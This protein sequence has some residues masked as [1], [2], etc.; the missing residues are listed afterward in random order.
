MS[1]N[2]NSADR[3]V[4]DLK[5]K[6]ATLEHALAA[7]D[8][9]FTVHDRQGRFLY[10]NPRG[11]AAQNLRLEDV[12]G[13]N[14]RELGF[15]EEVGIPFDKQVEQVFTEEVT[16]RTETEFPTKDG[17]RI[18]ENVL[19]PA[20]D[21]T[22]A[23]VALVATRQDITEIKT[24]EKAARESEEQL[25][26]I[27][28]NIP[29][30]VAYVGLDD[31]CYRSVNNKFEQ[32][33][34]RPREEIIGQH[35]KD[36]IGES[37]Y[38]FA[39]KYID[40]VRSGQAVS[41]ENIFEVEDGKRWIEVNYAPTF[42]A[43]GKPEGI[44]VL[45]FDITERKRADEALRESQEQFA[46]F[47]DRLP[48]GVFIKEEDSTVAYVN[49]YIKDVL[50]GEHWVGR[51]AHAAFPEHPDLAEA[52]MADDRNAL[53][54][55]Q[56]EIEEAM[57]DKDGNERVFITTKFRISRAN[58]SPLLGGIGL[59]I[60]DRVKAERELAAALD[61]ARHLRDQAEKANRAKDIF[62]ANMS[63][64]LRTP[65]NAI[66]GYS[67]LMARDVNVTHTQQEYLETIARSGEYLL[68]LIN[69]VLTMSKIEAGRTTLQENA[70]DLHQQIYGL[71]EM[72]QLRADHKGLKLLLDIAPDVPNYIYADESKLRQVLINLLSN[73]VKFTFEGGVTLRIKS[74]LQEVEDT[75]AMLFI[76]VEDTGAGI[77]Q[78]EID[79]LFEPFTQTTSGQQSQEGTG[80]GLSISQQFVNL[81]GGKLS[82]RSIVEQGTVFHVQIPVTLADEETV[83]KLELS[84]QRR[85][86]GVEPAQTAPDGGPF[87]LLV[88][89]DNVPNRELLVKLLTPFGFELRTADNGKESVE[90]WE[91]W[92]PHLVWMDMR[93]PVMDGYEATRQIKARA[94]TADRPVIVVA[95][96]AS[97]FD[98]DRETIFI[99][100]C[101][102]LIRKPFRE[103]EIFDA[104]HRH[105][106]LRFIYETSTPAPQETERMPSQDMR[107]AIERLPVEWVA[108]LR[109][110]AIAL[111]VERTL[112]LVEVIRPRES[113]LADTLAAWVGDFEF[114]KLLALI[115]SQ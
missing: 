22:G 70:F 9:H 100:G 16:I 44:V 78:E 46:L 27:T 33:Y 14:W 28:D 103:H 75:G 82:V 61:T 62:L 109:Q 107:A 43:Q 6:I 8:V 38:Q 21:D 35:I 92:Q 20:R 12:E 58:K 15:P 81:M 50:G 97:A 32:A 5:K 29:A 34:A 111:D 86:T 69:N 87:R 51:D 39:L 74:Q 84:P 37:N 59:D 113:H 94:K 64:E 7:T 25:R 114:D 2:D 91:Q 54:Q 80:L 101:D 73:A 30:Y 98:E 108:E 45:S 88:V 115:P 10:V 102:D 13:K 56:T 66:L 47:M 48:H 3:Q 71:K 95:L 89:E 79:T 11:L 105:L 31:L 1:E 63:H 99:A 104:L 24:A 53:A 4:E 19:Q 23:V 17:P 65:L 52:M 41:Y 57:P 60:T 85:V 67:Q 112:I 96:T 42:D 26:F 93:L 49:Q 40:I 72:F 18:F 110:A 76:E 106:G 36:I 90:L 83:E 77:A 68:N 55:G